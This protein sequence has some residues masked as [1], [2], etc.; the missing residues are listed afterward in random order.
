MKTTGKVLLAGCVVLIAIGAGGAALIYT[1]GHEAQLPEEATIGPNPTLP[2]PSETLLPTVNIAP[3]KGWPS[4]AMPVAYEGLAVTPY[5]TGLDHPRWLYVLPNGDVLVAK[6]NAPERPD[7]GGGIKGFVFGF[8][9]KRAGAGV[10]SA[11]RISLLRDA[12]GDG[13]AE[14][15]TAFLTGLN[16]PFGMALV[17]QDLYVANTDAGGRAS[18]RW[19]TAA[20]WRSSVASTGPSPWSWACTSRSARS[21]LFLYGTDDQKARW[22]PDLASGRKLAAFALTEPNVGSDAYNLETRADRQPDGSWLLNGEKRWIGNGDRDILTVFARGEQGHV[23]L[24]V[25]KGMEGLEHRPA[26]R[27]PRPQGEPPAARPLRQRARARRE[28]ARRAGR[29]VPHRDAD[30]QQRPDVDGHRDLGRHEA[31][32][33][34]RARARPAPASSSTGTSSTS[35][36]SRRSSPGWRARSTGSSPAYLTTGLVDRGESDFSL[37]SAMTK[38]AASDRAGTPSTA[39]FQLLG[40]E[41]YMAKHPLAKALRDFRIFPIFEGSNDVMRAYVALNGIKALSEELKELGDINLGDPIGSLGVLAD[42]VTSRVKREVR[43][44]QV[45]KSHDA[46]SGLAEPVGEQVKR[47]RS[48]TEGLLARSTRAR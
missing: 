31:L 32:P 38:V 45:T 46:L 29:R 37:E 5:A 34:A 28:P 42:Y 23:A 15:K 9:Q 10:P 22:L 1:A 20:S 17:G 35:R 14:E 36:W 4:G 11:N 8:M 39:P 41:A 19:A 16:S 7:Q 6:S 33:R 12:D 3:A 40:G 2:P 30:P 21:R 26:L 18:R 25:E 43:P 44:D 24:I 47:L 48:V 13:L 27:D